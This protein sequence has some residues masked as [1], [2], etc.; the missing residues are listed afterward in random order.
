MLKSST[1]NSKSHTKIN[2][3]S[4]KSL[5]LNCLK[6]EQARIAKDLMMHYAFF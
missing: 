4:L 6:S 1:C 2:N 5:D 3:S